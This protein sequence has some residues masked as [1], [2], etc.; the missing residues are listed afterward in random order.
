MAARAIDTHAHLFLADFASDIAAVTYRAQSVCE[1]VFLPNLDATTLPALQKLCQE[2][3]GFYKGLIG[4]HP[5]HVKADFEN[6]LAALGALLP[7]GEWIGIGEVGLDFYRSPQTRQWQEAAFSAQIEWAVAYDLPLSIHFR[8]ALEETVALLRPF[9]GQVRGV[10]HCFTEG[11]AEAQRILDLG[12]FVGIGGVVTYPSALA[13]RAA[14]PYIPLDRIL[15]E[16]DSPYLTPVPLRGRRNESAYLSY[17]IR[18]L[19]ELYRLPPEAI[20]E[21]TTQN[22]RLLFLT[23]GA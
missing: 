9:V 6:E 11:R 10:F 20:V 18:A 16:T 12:F 15:L 4:L 7:Q 14:I 5:L 19:A 13:L 3:P 22:A 1:A 8:G 21:Q 17:I 23:R 2:A